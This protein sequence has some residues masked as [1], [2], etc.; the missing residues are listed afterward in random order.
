MEI[1]YAAH[2]TFSDDIKKVSLQGTALGFVDLPDMSVR[3]LDKNPFSKENLKE[4]VLYFWNNVLIKTPQENQ[5]PEMYWEHNTKRQDWHLR[6]TLPKM[7]I[8][9]ANF[10]KSLD[11]EI[12]DS[13]LLDEAWESLRFTDSEL[14]L[15]TT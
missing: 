9:R 1:P 8:N 10:L 4:R 2:T 14:E 12:Q 6:V 7:R 11:S 15:L 5:V 3:I 13:P